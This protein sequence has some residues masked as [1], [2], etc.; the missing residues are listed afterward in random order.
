MKIIIFQI[1]NLRS[2][3]LFYFR[4]KQIHV[5]GV[6]FMLRKLIFVLFIIIAQHFG[7]CVCE[8]AS[9]QCDKEGENQLTCREMS[10]VKSSE[11][12]QAKHANSMALVPYT[13]RNDILSQFHQ[14]T[15]QF[16]FV[17]H[18]L[19]INQDWD[20]LGVAAVVWDAVKIYIYFYHVLVVVCCGVSNT[21]LMI[22]FYVD[23]DYS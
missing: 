8:Y 12:T 18:T 2:N 17:G 15:R 22:L 4:C 23:A 20:K 6:V 1:R 14:K 9:Q 11:D 3:N 5:G 10:Q 16:H 19:N 21:L 13:A 7:T